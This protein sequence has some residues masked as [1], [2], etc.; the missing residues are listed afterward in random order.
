MV[1]LSNRCVQGRSHGGGGGGGEGGGGGGGGGA[2]YPHPP[3]GPLRQKVR[4]STHLHP[5]VLPPFP[6][7]STL[8]YPSSTSITKIW[9]RLWLHTFRSAIISPCL[10]A[11]PI[12]HYMFSHCIQADHRLF[13]WQ[14]DIV[15]WA[16]ITLFP[17][18]LFT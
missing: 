14:S 2:L 16:D 1:C 11:P 10:N 3:F 4:K 13:A 17:Q 5:P 9:M 18:L 8:F 6:P 12:A 15:T 7:F